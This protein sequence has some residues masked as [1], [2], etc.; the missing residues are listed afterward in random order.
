MG[1]QRCGRAR[2]RLRV[3][4]YWFTADGRR[5]GPL[6]LGK[7]TTR[8][9]R[10]RDRRSLSGRWRGRGGWRRRVQG[11]GWSC[12]RGRP[13]PVAW[14]GA[15]RR[16]RHLPGW[17]RMRRVGL[18]LIHL[19]QGGLQPGCLRCSFRGGF[20]RNLPRLTTRS[21]RSRRCGGRVRGQLHPSLRT[22]SRRLGRAARSGLDGFGLGRCR[23]SGFCGGTPGT[24]LLGRTR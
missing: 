17:G 20:V 6:R 9:G 13:E 16:N 5:D 4:R 23:K 15:I 10:Q 22:T 1:R 3:R 21:F 14:M 19:A 7:F 24:R 2:S 12:V 11:G 18:R 8:C